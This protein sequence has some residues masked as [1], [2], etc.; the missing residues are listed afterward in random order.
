MISE[1]GGLSPLADVQPPTYHQ[2]ARMPTIQPEQYRYRISSITDENENSE[3]SCCS[4]VMTSPVC[5]WLSAVADMCAYQC[6]IWCCE[7]NDE[8]DLVSYVHHT[9]EGQYIRRVP[10]LVPEPL[11]HDYDMG[12][13]SLPHN[14]EITREHD[15]L[16]PTYDEIAIET[17]Q[18]PSYAELNTGPVLQDL[19]YL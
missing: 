18:L 13:A 7:G 17:E 9:T 10:E 8:V 14:N 5:H 2:A 6:T 15:D 11:R 1:P 12:R 16:P 19:A 3:S 4:Q